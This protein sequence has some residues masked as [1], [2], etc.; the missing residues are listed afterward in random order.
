MHLLSV[1][2]LL[3]SGCPRLSLAWYGAQP[4]RQATNG[5]WLAVG[6]RFVR[7]MPWPPLLDWFV[8]QTG[9]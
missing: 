5:H 6:G 4:R 8:R 2:G 3:A 7:L 9:R 1:P